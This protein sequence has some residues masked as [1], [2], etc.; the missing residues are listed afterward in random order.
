[1]RRE[2]SITSFNG[3]WRIRLSVDGKRRSFGLHDTREQAE[4]VL[5]RE[6]V[7]LASEILADVSGAYVVRRAIEL[8]S[9]I[10]GASSATTS[11]G[12]RLNPRS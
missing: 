6:D 1:M 5:A 7:K 2:G 9:V 12:I 4:A 11:E 8:A 3:K 10:L